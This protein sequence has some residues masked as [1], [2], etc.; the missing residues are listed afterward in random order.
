[1]LTNNF[2]ITVGNLGSI[3]R[4]IQEEIIHINSMLPQALEYV[5]SEM[6]NNLK[7]HIHRDWYAPYTP[8]TYQRRTDQP[9]LGTPLGSEKNMTVSVN[10]SRLTFIYDPVSDHARPHWRGRASGDDLSSIIQDGSGGG[11]DGKV[12]ARAFWNAF[13]EEQFH[14]GIACALQKAFER[15]Y[16]IEI[17]AADLPA[18]GTNQIN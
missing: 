11:W 3:H 17:S 1:M 18:D 12:P 4:D 2:K 6:I 5:G 16:S 15:S 9:S 7:S 8:R 14:H 10:K 13:A